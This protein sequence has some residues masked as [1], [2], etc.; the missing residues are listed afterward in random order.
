M[1]AEEYT[2]GEPDSQG[3]TG[4]ALT[5]FVV[6]TPAARQGRSLTSRAMS[7]FPSGFSPQC[8]PAMRNPLGMGAKGSAYPPDFAGQ[9]W[10]D[11]DTQRTPECSSR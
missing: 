4:A 2:D 1:D 3:T 5:R 6:N 7:G 11:Q 8:V 10:T 9:S